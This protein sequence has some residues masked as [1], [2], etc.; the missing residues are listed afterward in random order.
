MPVE[1][2]F[3][4]KLSIPNAASAN[5]SPDGKFIAYNPIYPSFT[6]WKH[7]RGGTI[8][9]IWYVNLDD[10]STIIV[11]HGDGGSNDAYPI[12]KKDKIYFMS[13][14]NGEFNLFSYDIATKEI[15]Q[16]TDHADFPITNIR[17][18]ENE[19]VYNQGAYIHVY[20]IASGTSRKVTLNIATDLAG[21]RTR[22]AEGNKWVNSI[23]ISPTGK[24]AVMDFRGEIVTV[25]AEKG[26]P[27]NITNSPGA[28]EVSPAWSPD[29]KKIAYFSD[30]SREYALY[31]S[32]LDGS[33]APAKVELNGTGF[34]NMLNWSPD[35]KKISFTDNGRNLYYYSLTD[36]KVTKVATENLYEPG[37]FGHMKGNWSPD[38][39][40]ITYTQIADSY[41][42]VVYV[43]SLSADKSYQISDGL[44]D[45]VDPVFDKNGKYLYFFAS[46]DAGPVRH[47][48]AQSSL[49]M[50]MSDAIYLVALQSDVANPFAKENDEETITDDSGE[51]R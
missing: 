37:A 3:P 34:Y 48:F 43:Y 19:I 35:S 18:G 7:Y 41:F 33:G 13:D 31:I 21:L 47:W 45:A 40:W 39:K 15:K 20:D 38:S 2:G 30:L 17:E 24:R 9:T 14:R 11:P 36:N 5:Y 50:E 26:D 10:L 29:G 49:D 46:T 12:L 27:Q 51:K 16:L 4:T 6:Q 25:P 8:S 42:R 28:H 23:G 32:S 44:S 1:G 22:Y